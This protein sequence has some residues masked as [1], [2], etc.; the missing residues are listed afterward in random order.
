MQLPPKPSPG[1]GGPKPGTVPSAPSARVKFRHPD[2]GE[3]T[4]GHVH[5]TP[6]AR[7]A[8][9]VDGTGT[10]HRVPHGHY[11]HAD[12]DGGEDGDKPSAQAVAKAAHAHVKLGADQPLA[13]YGA[14]A[15]LVVGGVRK[16]PV[17]ELQ[18]AD[19]AIQDGK[20]LVHPDR[21]QTDDADVVKVVQALLGRTKKGPLFTVQGKPI[22]EQALTTYVRRYGAP[23]MGKAASPAH[24]PAPMEKASAGAMILPH[25][26]VP[27]IAWDV[28]GYHCTLAKSAHGVLCVS[29]FGPN[30]P[31]P[32]HEVVPNF[33][34]ARAM[35]TEQ[36]GHL[37]NGRTPTRG[38]FQR[39]AA[40]T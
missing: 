1:A 6:G 27:E 40:T 5:G 12:E 19:V 37:R 34:A 24:E 20:L 33:A 3:E 25:L 7:G 23:T 8:T 10:T 14:A 2:T 38:V 21:L 15:L 29:I 30:M 11:M 9:V 36:V 4:H 22:T 26:P 16:T 39:T 13:V 17:H 18:V 32:L 35:A 31:M 28:D